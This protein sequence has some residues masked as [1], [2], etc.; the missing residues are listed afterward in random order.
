MSAVS[1][2]NLTPIQYV[3]VAMN[4]CV[5]VIKRW[6]RNGGKL[7]RKEKEQVFLLIEI[8]TAQL[9]RCISD[10][11]RELG[12]FG[13]EFE[14][15]RVQNSCLEYKSTDADNEGDPG[16][17]LDQPSFPRGCCRLLNE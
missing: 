2:M 8:L 13:G 4:L 1:L 17:P 5:A 3:V 11:S 15:P 9:F 16:D 14:V 12:K 10:L 6:Q 7:S